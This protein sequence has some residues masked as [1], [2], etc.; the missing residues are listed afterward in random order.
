MRF[1]ASHP[2]TGK[3]PRDGYTNPLVIVFAMSEPNHSVDIETRCRRLFEAIWI[4]GEAS[5]IRDLCAPDIIVNDPT[6]PTEVTGSDGYEAFVSRIMDQYRTHDLSIEDA[7]LADGTV[8]IQFGGVAS[9]ET[10]D[11]MVDE[12]T[13]SGI[14]VMKIDDGQIVERAGALLDETNLEFFIEGFHGMVIRPGDADYDEARSVWNGV[15]DSYPAVIAKCAGVADVIDA[16]NFARENDLLVSIRGGGHNVAGTAVCDSGLVIDLSEMNGIHVD[17]DAQTA[18]AQAGATWADL[19][20]ETQRF[21]LATPGGVVSTTGIAGLTLGGGVGWLRRK[22]GLSIDN[23]VS[24][25]LVTAEG[26]FLTVSE[27]KHPDLFWGIR[28]G[29]GNFGV[30]TSFEYRLHPIG[31]EVMFVGALYPLETARNILPEWRD[32]MESAPEEISSQAVFWSIPEVS[33]FPEDVRG[34]PIVAIV[35]MHCG[36]AEEGK[37]ALQPLC[38]LDEPLVDLSDVM[39][40][41]DVQ[42]LYDP[43]L[44]EGELYYW[45][46]LD[47]D[48]FD[49]EVIDALIRIA[50]NRPSPNTLM[51]I[52]HQGG[53]MNAVG[54][55]E[56]AYGPRDTTYLLSLDSTWSDPAD[57]D[58]NIAWTR[59]V[60]EEMH[61][62]SDGGLYL[63]FPGFGEEGEK[64][65]RAGHGAEIHERL[66]ELKTEYDPD[67]LFR[68]NQNVKPAE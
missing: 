46:S 55:T 60:W 1:T 22:Y 2:P 31:P 44:P 30:V 43:F 10:S 6:K 49:A 67:N 63:N 38:E 54:P 65:L 5:H 53:A 23:L 28:G 36:P 26:E 9:M 16:V 42:Q 47:L 64:L 18:R 3:I 14:E 19:D 4:A 66:V 27:H 37:H 11:V 29:G 52:W 39:P 17:L 40:F 8:A 59:D 33:V 56:T 58:A 57:T 34:E 20:R 24:V 50:E 41:T 25:D 68:L 7:R 15:I 32:F 35:A 13:V 51:P 45:K 61:R 48:R 62:Y 12:R 21:G